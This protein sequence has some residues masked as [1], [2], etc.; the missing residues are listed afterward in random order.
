MREDDFSN[1]I[2]GCHRLM[3]PPASSD[4]STNSF[5][6]AAGPASPA[7]HGFDLPAVQAAKLG[8]QTAVGAEEAVGLIRRNVGH[9]NQHDNFPSARP[10]G[11][12][13]ISVE[14]AANS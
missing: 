11:P 7:A 4:G 3:R 8:V 1:I 14:G 2:H 5:S 13:A 10:A 6:A 12:R 9:F